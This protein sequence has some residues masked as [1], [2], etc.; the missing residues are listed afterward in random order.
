MPNG[1]TEITGEGAENSVMMNCITGGNFTQLPPAIVIYA[2]ATSADSMLET[3]LSLHRLVSGS[4]PTFFLS[5][6]LS[7]MV[8]QTEFLLPD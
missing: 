7:L 5:A 3:L 8:F 2:F 1:T 4:L 6:V